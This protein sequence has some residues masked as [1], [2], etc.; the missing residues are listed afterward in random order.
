MVQRSLAKTDA[1]PPAVTRPVCVTRSLSVGA[2]AKPDPEA[3][4][5]AAAES[6]GATRY[7][8]RMLAEARE[9]LAAAVEFAATCF[10]STA[11]IKAVFTFCPSP[12]HLEASEHS[13]PLEESSRRRAARLGLAVAAP[14]EAP[15][16]DCEP[17]PIVRRHF[18]CSVCMTPRWSSPRTSLALPCCGTP[19]CGDCWHGIVLAALDAGDA[20]GVECPDLACRS[21]RKQRPRHSPGPQPGARAV[22]S[23]IGGRAAG[24]SCK[25]ALAAG[26]GQL[27]AVPPEAR[28]HFEDLNTLAANRHAR[29]CPSCRHV[30]I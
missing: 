17:S 6:R 28:R 4:L 1:E 12:R 24:D 23:Q 22:Q 21:R 3:E 19:F 10:D 15:L 7:A 30:Q 29:R 20:R 5:L 11:P 9:R 13:A 26:L 18:V 25:A 27:T 8:A 16:S 2:A 14:R